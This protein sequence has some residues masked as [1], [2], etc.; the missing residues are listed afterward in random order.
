MSGSHAAIGSPRG[1]SLR[2]VGEGS[3]CLKQEQSALGMFPT[4]SSHAL[5]PADASGRRD[6]SLDKLVLGR[7][8]SSTTRF[9]ESL[10]KLGLDREKTGRLEES[11]EKL[12]L[13]PEKKGSTANETTPLV[14]NLPWTL[15]EIRLVVG[16]FL[17]VCAFVLGT[18]FWFPLLA[19]FEADPSLKWDA[20]NT[21]LVSTLGTAAETCGL[22][23]F[24]PLADSV[25]S[26]YCLIFEALFIIVGISFVV[27]FFYE[28]AYAITTV[29]T[30]ACFLKGMMWPSVSNIVTRNLSKTKQ[31][32]AFLAMPLGSRCADVVGAAILGQV[33]VGMH[34][35]WSFAGEILLLVV[36]GM[37]VLVLCLLPAGLQYTSTEAAFQRSDTDATDTTALKWHRMLTSFNA[38]LAFLCL[39]GTYTVFA[40]STYS[41]VIMRDTFHVS[42][43]EAAR[44]TACFP[45]GN[46]IGLLGGAVASYYMGVFSSRQYYCLQCCLGSFALAALSQYKFTYGT[47]LML[48]AV[49]GIGMVISAYVPYLAYA[50]SAKPCDRGFLVATLDGAASIVG[51][52]NTLFFGHLRVQATDPATVSYKMY[53]TSFVGLTI[54]VISMMV[55]FHRL[56]N[57]VE[58][59]H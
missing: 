45:L 53:A 58:S 27:V 36:I 10:E 48:F 28:D 4:A 5:K 9:E 29:C 44:A 23:V 55:L 15:R 11:L 34:R 52:L 43:G 57:N 49:V 31:D 20:S 47:T 18:Y 54:S 17:S 50:A 22:L 33:M 30:S 12:G 3:R 51:V 59:A 40:L 24:G 39:C 14:V 19:A 41:V 8:Q 16:C 46:A 37:F 2:R 32:M 1:S 35:P 7:S 42:V 26:H 6:E 56:Q 13:D 38:W 25:P 21:A